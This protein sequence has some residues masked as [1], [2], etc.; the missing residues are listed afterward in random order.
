VSIGAKDLRSALPDVT[1]TLSLAGL[2]GPVEIFRDQLGVPHVRAE[3]LAD[4]FFAQGF[5]HAQ[6]RLWQMEFD[7][8]RATGRWAECAGR[9]ALEQDTL[10]RRLALAATSQQDY[11]AFDDE[12]RL[13][14]DRY[15]A[16]INAFIESTATLPIEFTLLGI[17]P[18]RWEPWQCVAVFKVRH[19]LMGVW[20]T[21]LW[22]ARVLRA[23]GP[24]MAVKLGTYG[25]H[26][27]VLIVPPG[28]EYSAELADLADLLP[29]EAALNEA[30]EIGGG[31][32]NWV[33]AGSRTASGK[34]LVAGD[35]HRG[36]DVPNV[37]YQNH[38]ACPEFDVAG[39]SFG[40]VPGFP[41]FAHNATVAWAIT[42]AMA[43]YQDLYIER[44]RAD[45]NGKL[46]Y[47]YMG[48]WR[49]A[50]RRQETIAV[51]DAAPVTIDIVRTHHGPVVV[52]DPD[53]GHAITMRYTATDVPNPGL[54]CLLPMLRARTVDEL[55]ESMRHWI[56]PCNNMVMAD[57]EGTIAYL[58][59]GRVPIRTMANAWLPVPGWTGE[60]EWQGDVPF[61]ELPRER[62][63][64]T[65][66][67]ATANNRVVGWDYP[68]Y[69][70]LNYAPPHR[71]RRV[72]DRLTALENATIA[73]MASVHA[74]RLSLPSAVFRAVIATL[75][76]ADERVRQ[77]QRLLA[78]WDG[79]MDRDLAAPTVY[80]ATRD[81]LARQLI[82]RPAFAPLR[83][84]PFTEEPLPLGVAGR[85]WGP[86]LTMIEAD[87][88]ALL[89]PGQRWPDPIE[90]ALTAA[91]ATLSESL[92]PDP[93]GWRWE[94]L[95]TTKPLHPLAGA[96]P[97][98]AELL[99][100]P[101]IAIGGDSDTV[102]AA[103]FAPGAGFTL[104]STSV[105]RYAFDLNDWDNSGWIVPLGASAHP[106][107][108]HYADQR[109]DWSDV[110]LRPMLYDWEK[111]RAAAE[112]TQR[113]EP[114]G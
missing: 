13:V 32:N 72:V 62:N 103:T 89:D 3:S 1:S 73:D 92:G 49:T 85:I 110:Q 77:A 104:T 107:S 74:D 44:F 35:P 93:T 34:P 17:V 69:L 25:V 65:G 66:F 51:R 90:A 86:V 53:Q 70:G 43:D 11:A 87:D 101:S 30:A 64:A 80:A 38:L 54:R 106:G 48:D 21:K 52:G 68:Y 102:Q 28:G 8:R 100:P 14:F 95:H 27:G 46:R 23:L 83:A 50:A 20:G 33:V 6:D 40:G 111:V 71:A 59:R 47:E 98:A 55:D 36:L 26:D 88:T 112:T 10:M 91:V 56:D 94:R 2:A 42:H 57:R 78:E 37:Y 113:L 15:A 24:E 76:P 75:T 22:R 9:A 39:F 18:D 63:P 99:N 84:N 67:I 58:H 108:P 79:T 45:D 97:E 5:V 7:R 105:A 61:D 114:A 19:T 81:Q 29:G 82:A 60:H 12:T 4:A 109:T 31:S 16:G 41:H 96:F